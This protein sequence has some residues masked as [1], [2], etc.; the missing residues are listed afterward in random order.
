MDNLPCHIELV[1]QDL[2]RSTEFYKSLF[3]WQIID[4]G[5]EN[6]RLIKFGE[7]FPI[8]GAILKTKDKIAHEKQWPMIYIRVDSIEETLK[9]AQKLGS[10]ITVDI[11]TIPHRGC[12]AA[13]TD[14]DGNQIALWKEVDK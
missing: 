5:I 4:S 10:V 14:L 11:K 8:G 12:W 13:F 9:K 6:Y 1:S 3:N 2:E 7:G